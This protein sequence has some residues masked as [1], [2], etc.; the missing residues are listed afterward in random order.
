MITNELYYDT[1]INSLAFS[2]NIKRDLNIYCSFFNNNRDSFLYMGKRFGNYLEKHKEQNI[3][4]S[5]VKS[6]IYEIVNYLYEKFPYLTNKINDS[7]KLLLNGFLN[8][9]KRYLN[10]CLDNNTDYIRKQI[11]MRD[12]GV[13][14]KLSPYWRYLGQ[15]SDNTIDTFKDK[16]YTSI[17]KDILF[18][19]LL[20]EPRDSFY[21]SDYKD[22]TL[23][24][25]FYRSINY[26]WLTSPEFRSNNEYYE[27]IKFMISSNLELL[28]DLIISGD[29]DDEEFADIHSASLRLL[30]I[31][32]NKKDV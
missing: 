12:Y 27:R 15:I 3:F 19:N 2:P 9:V 1:L 23:D 22:F 17:S 18:I 32:V 11:L 7:D 10:C 25:G 28:I 6:N 14:S 29:F 31:K 16:Y 8:S 30:K 24:K 21:N 13:K 20:N 5:R 4:D 26:F